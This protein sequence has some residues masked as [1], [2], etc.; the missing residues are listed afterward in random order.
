MVRALT[1]DGG[2]LSPGNVEV[3]QVEDVEGSFFQG[4]GTDSGGLAMSEF[5]EGK[6]GKYCGGGRLSDAPEFCSRDG[7]RM[8]GEEIRLFGLESK[9]LPTGK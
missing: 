1:V 3:V 5:L 8:T 4:G 2:D 9:V 6:E 7:G